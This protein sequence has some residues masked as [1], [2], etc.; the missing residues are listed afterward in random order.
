MLGF[1]QITEQQWKQKLQYELQGEDFNSTLNNTDFQEISTKPLYLQKDYF[2]FFKQYSPQK[3]VALYVYSFEKLKHDLDFWFTNGVITFHIKLHNKKNYEELLDH[4]PAKGTYF[5]I[6][7]FL[8]N[9]V[10][11]QLESKAKQLGLNIHFLW[12]ALGNFSQSGNWYRSKTDD[13]KAIKTYFSNKNRP[14]FIN[15]SIFEQAGGT[16]IQQIAYTLLMFASYLTHCGG[17]CFSEIWIKT[18]TGEN[19][20]FEI[21][22]LQAFRLSFESIFAYLNIKPTTIHIWTSP[23][24][25]NWTLSKT[26]QNKNLQNLSLQN[27]V[28]GCANWISPIQNEFYKKD[29]NH[30]LLPVVTYLEQMLQFSEKFPANGSY[31]ISNLI[32]DIC[33]KSLKRFE[34]LSE[35]DYI[36]WMEHHVIQ[37]Q[38]K[39]KF[40][41]R[42]KPNIGNNF[43]SPEQWEI[44]PFTKRIS[45]KTLVEPLIPRR[46]SEQQEQQYYRQAKLSNKENLSSI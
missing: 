41:Q 11:G 39:E 9:T 44:L 35:K 6:V 38:I 36:W 15:A 25:L 22:K 31:Y 28:W 33:Q 24:T 30:L 12:D 45:R 37:R 27:A 34:T 3:A 10:L 13:I 40:L 43:I 8:E 29:N 23:S 5:L 19:T 14:L 18:R 26:Y 4:L 1:P 46:L 21:A 20:F 16:I 2:A 7:S 17:A 32:Y 42:E